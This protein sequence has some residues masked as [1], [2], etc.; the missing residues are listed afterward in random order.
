MTR[1]AS[2][3]VFVPYEEAYGQNFDDMQ[4][5]MP[6]LAKIRRL[7]GYEPK[8]SLDDALKIIIATMRD[9]LQK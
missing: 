7:I 9:E 1:S 5:R 3:I 6:N 2:P 8:T 4:R